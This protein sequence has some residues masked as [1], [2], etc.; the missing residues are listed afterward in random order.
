MVAVQVGDMKSRQAADE[1][2]SD[3]VV[4]GKDRIAVGGN[5][6]RSLVPGN[7]RDHHRRRRQGDNC[8]PWCVAPV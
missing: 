2:R 4:E 1:S 8:R 3:V 5:C 7:G 6:A